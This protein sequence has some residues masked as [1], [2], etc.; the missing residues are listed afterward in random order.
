MKMGASGDKVGAANAERPE[1][2]IFGRVSSS[3][4]LPAGKIQ[5]RE[6]TKGDSLT[7][8][9]CIFD[10]FYEKRL[11]ESPFAPFALRPRIEGFPAF[12]RCSTRATAVFSAKPQWDGTGCPGFR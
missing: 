11:G 7:R 8:H 4:V 2:A 6:G 5:N 10:S 1:G 9:N 12:R 3:P